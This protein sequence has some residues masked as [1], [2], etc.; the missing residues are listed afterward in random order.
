MDRQQVV[1]LVEE[2]EAEVNNGGFDQF[3]FNSSGDNSAETIE[4]LKLIGACAMADILTRAASKFP[5]QCP[6]PNRFDR[7]RL[8][9]E[10]SPDADG[11]DELDREFYA[12]PDNLANLLEKFKP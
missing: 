12:Y 9:R 5:D 10:V 6:P 8:L 4:A 3:F 2:L 7:Q 11:F 1:N